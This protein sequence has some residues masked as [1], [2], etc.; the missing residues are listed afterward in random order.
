MSI[1]LEV[2]YIMLYICH[3]QLK[4]TTFNNRDMKEQVKLF[5]AKGFK[6]VKKHYAGTTLKKGTQRVDI[7]QFPSQV[8]VLKM[9][10]SI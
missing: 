1:Y 9:D 6:V 5:R 10:L 7:I 8:Q 3:V 2:V 4:Q